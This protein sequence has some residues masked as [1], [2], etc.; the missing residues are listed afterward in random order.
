MSL[1]N[2]PA[3]L[4]HS[5][6]VVALGAGTT[7]PALQPQSPRGRRGAWWCFRPSSAVVTAPVLQGRLSGCWMGGSALPL[8][9]CVC[10]GLVY[11]KCGAG[12]K[13]ARSSKIV[14]AS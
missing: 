1:A 14:H 10:A 9:G 5:R 13:R 11:L 8:G 7:S 6:H 12:E 3:P 2:S 4:P